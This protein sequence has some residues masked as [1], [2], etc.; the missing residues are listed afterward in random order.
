MSLMLAH[1][2]CLV[3]TTRSLQVKNPRFTDHTHC[4]I[5][6]SCQTKEQESKL[7]F[8]SFSSLLWALPT[9]HAMCSVCVWCEC[10]CGGGGG[11]GGGLVG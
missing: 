3:C 8:H 4:T 2:I 6:I 5:D 10:V 1:V 11:G 7:S 9:S